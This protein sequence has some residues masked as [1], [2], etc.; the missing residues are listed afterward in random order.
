MT[1]V[2]QIS[3]KASSKVSPPVHVAIDFVKLELGWGIGSTFEVLYLLAQI[4]SY[5]S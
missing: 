5:M 2:A 4:F 1:N 3:Q